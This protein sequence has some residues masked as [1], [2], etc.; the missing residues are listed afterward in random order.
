MSRFVDPRAPV[1]LTESQ[2]SDLKTDPRVVQYRALRDSLSKT[3]RDTYG[4][5]EKAKGT[6]L[7]EMYQKASLQLKNVK[8]K[9]CNSAKKAS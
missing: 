5:I 3:L 1:G 8:N 9:L 7:Y 2:V 6:K 4:T